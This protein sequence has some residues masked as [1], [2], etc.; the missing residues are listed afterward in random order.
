MRKFQ[1]RQVLELLQTLR[2]AQTAGLYADCQ[3][4]AIQLLEFIDDA[5]GEGTQTAKLLQEYYELLYKASVGEADEKQLRKHLFKIETGVRSE[6]RPNRIEA[7]FLSYKASMSDS[8]ESVYLAAKADPD[9]DAYFIPIPYFDRKND[10][11]LEEAHIESVDSYDKRFELTDWK[12]Y[13]IEARRPDM[14]FTFAPF[15]EINFITAVHPDFFCERLRNLTD[16]LVYS[17]YFVTS[18]G[19]EPHSCT[20][21]GCIYAHKVVLQSNGLREQYIYHYKKKFGSKFGRPEE[22]FVAIGSPKY[23]KVIQT[24]RE[25]CSMPREWRELAEGRKIVL[26]NT[27]ISS[28]LQGGEQYLKKL[29]HVLNAFRSRKDAALWWRPHPLSSATYQSMRPGLSEEYEQLVAAYRREGWGIYD[30]TPDL[31]RA[32]AMSDAYYGDQSSLISMYQATGKPVMMQDAKAAGDFGPDENIPIAYLYDAG[33]AF[34]FAALTFNAL[35]KMDK[36]SWKTEYMG[37]FEGEATY[38]WRLYNGVCAFGGRLYFAPFAAEA[39]G[40]YDIESGRFERIELPDFDKTIRTKVKYD[41]LGKTHGVI[42]ANGRLFFSLVSFPGILILDPS[43]HRWEIVDGWI[44][45]LNELIFDAETAYFTKAV[46]DNKR[47][48][49]FF[50]CVTANAAAELD[51]NTHVTTVHKL[52]DQKNGYGDIIDVDGAFWLLSRQN[53]SIVRWDP[54]SGAVDEYQT[55][56]EGV[57]DGI[58]LFQRFVYIDD[59]LYFV[60]S[61]EE[62]TLEFDLNSKSF[63]QIEGF[64]LAERENNSE[65]THPLTFISMQTNNNERVYALA[66]DTCHLVEYDPKT[67]ACRE[68]GVRLSGDPAGREALSVRLLNREDAVFEKP[69]D[70]ALYEGPGLANAVLETLLDALVQPSPPPWLAKRIQKQAEL[71]RAE[72][73][74]GDGKAGEAIY[75]MCKKAVLG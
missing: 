4:V 59:R 66:W 62:N 57:I 52:G 9:C 23:D 55:G 15:D 68:E 56:L 51:L 38:A 12:R 74:H 54:G 31:H 11:S 13:D 10:G 61:R 24:K 53:A 41:P 70:C 25:D 18:G 44:E 26:Y 60:P 64:K 28:I 65:T 3:D 69:W 8:I 30:D 20:L 21:P 37:S 67:N 46:F 1:Q 32:I 49:L 27:S 5:E 19:V 2:E 72:I 29:D 36:Q 40:V 14:I 43:E 6:L 58:A 35:F 47:N 39:V 33:D 34:W 75:A 45:P 73:E 22:K 42:E 71:Q 50:A 17:P 16:M 63:A 48:C 7:V